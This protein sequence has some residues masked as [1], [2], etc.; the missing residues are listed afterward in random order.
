MCR[1]KS[2]TASVTPNFLLRLLIS[3]NAMMSS[4]N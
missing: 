2:L 4:L 3:K 1:L